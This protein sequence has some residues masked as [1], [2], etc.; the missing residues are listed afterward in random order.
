MLS[1]CFSKEKDSCG[2]PIVA[3]VPLKGFQSVEAVIVPFWIPLVVFLPL[4]FWLRGAV[5]NQ[6]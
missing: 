5:V 3:R 6:D 4:L 1:D 2:D